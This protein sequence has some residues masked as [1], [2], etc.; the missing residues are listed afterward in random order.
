MP[1]MRHAE[2]HAADA[3]GAAMVER[4]PE[5]MPDLCADRRAVWHPDEHGAMGDDESVPGGEDSQAREPDECAAG[6]VF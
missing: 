1:D 2:I 6:G 4:E 5:R 3:A